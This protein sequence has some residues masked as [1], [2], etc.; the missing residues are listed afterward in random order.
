[1]DNKVF[2]KRINRIVGQLRGIEKMIQQDRSCDEIIIQINAVKRAINGFT[3]EFLV[4]GFCNRLN[5]FKDQ[6]ELKRAI[7][8]AVDL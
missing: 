5:N 1:M 2:T 8:K 7:E 4:S 6:Q 3:K